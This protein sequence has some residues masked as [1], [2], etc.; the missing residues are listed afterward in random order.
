MRQSISS[1]FKKDKDIIKGNIPRNIIA[2]AL[3]LMIAALLQTTQNLIDMFWVGRLGTNAITAVAISG[4][5]IMFVFTLSLGLGVGA[6]SLVARNIGARNK[7][8]A[9]LVAS[10]SIVLGILLGLVTAVIGFFF[11]DKFLLMLGADSHVAGIGAG[12]LRI[13]LMGSTTMIVLFV[14]NYILN[15][16]GD[17]VNPMIFLGLANIF[18]MILDPIFIFGIGVPKMGVSG[19]ALATVIGQGIAMMMVLR[20]LTRKGAKVNITY[21]NLKIKRDI[22]RDMLRIGIPSSFQMFFRTVMYMAVV[23]LVAIFGMKA[24]AAFGIVMRL[25]MIMVMPALALGTAAA[26]FMGQNMGACQPDRA[27]ISVWTATWLDFG[28][29]F[30]VGT[31]FFIMPKSI[32]SFFNNDPVLLDMGSGFLRISAFFYCFMA[33][34]IV[35][36]RGLS[37]AGDTFVPMIITLLALWGYLVPVAHYLAKHTSLGLNGIWWAVATSY[38]VNAVLTVLWFESGMWRKRLPS[39]CR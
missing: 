22:L 19:A 11:S 28:I 17:V 31:V 8:G 29:M 7:E 5:V 1:L 2:L 36:N 16:A 25:H 33:F 6:M 30:V 10:Q 14:G 20:L 12:Y 24:V 34:G 21:A 38:V 39:S 27:R 18:N 3:P 35:L 15:A 4:T 9:V 23:S 37:G 13:L 26:T 32:I